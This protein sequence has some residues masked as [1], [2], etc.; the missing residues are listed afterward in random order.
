MT[1]IIEQTIKYS[2]KEEKD[3]K[4]SNDKNCLKIEKTKSS[5]DE[6]TNSIETKEVNSKCDLSLIKK[7][8]PAKI[9]EIEKMENSLFFEA[10]IKK[11]D[12]ITKNEKKD[13]KNKRQKNS[14]KIQKNNFFEKEEKKKLKKTKKNGNKRQSKLEEKESLLYKEIIYFSNFLLKLNWD[15]LDPQINQSSI[16]NKN[17]L[18]ASVF[19]YII[20]NGYFPKFVIYK[21]FS[22]ISENLIR[23]ISQKNEKSILI[24]FLGFLNNFKKNIIFEKSE[25]FDLEQKEIEEK[26]Q[27]LLKKKTKFKRS[28]IIIKDKIL[29]LKLR[30]KLSKH[31]NESQNILKKKKISSLLN[32]LITEKKKK[33][34]RITEIF[35]KIQ[36][37]RNS[38]K[39]EEEFFS[40]D[41]N[42]N[43]T[44]AKTQSVFHSKIP[45]T[46]ILYNLKTFFVLEEKFLQTLENKSKKIK[47][48]NI[49][50][51]SQNSKTKKGKLTHN[52][53][54]C[55]ICNNPDYN[56]KNQI[57]FCSTCNVSVHQNC[58]QLEKIPKN[59]WICDLCVF[60][61][62]QGKMVK[63]VFCPCLGGVLRKTQLRVDD[64]F[65]RKKN[66][67]FF[68][69][70]NFEG[71]LSHGNE[72]K[73]KFYQE[74]PPA[75]EIKL[76]YNTYSQIYNF[77]KEELDTLKTSRNIWAHLSCIFWN[78]KLEFK[79]G[80]LKNYQKINEK[81]F[82]AK[83]DI[84]QKKKQGLVVKCKIEGCKFRFHVECARRA[85]LTMGNSSTFYRGNCIFCPEHTPLPLK[86]QILTENKRTKEDI[87]KYLKILKRF[88]NNNEIET[89]TFEDK[90][91][92]E[93]KKEEIKIEKIVDFFDLQKKRLFREV[94]E[95]LKQKVDWK[96]TIKLSKTEN[97]YKIEKINLPKKF[98]FSHKIKQNAIL[99]KKIANKWDTTPFSLFRQ[100]QTL[101]AEVLFLFQNQKKF[102]TKKEIEST[103]MTEDFIPNTEGFGTETHC[104]CKKEWKGEVMVSCDRCDKWYHPK[105]LGFAQ[106]EEIR[107]DFVF[108]FQCRENIEQ[109]LGIGWEEFEKSEGKR[110]IPVF[111]FSLKFE[112]RR[113]LREN[114]RE[115]RRLLGHFGNGVVVQRKSGKKKVVVE[116]FGGIE[117][118][119]ERLVRDE[120]FE[121]VL[122]FYGE[123]GFEVKRFF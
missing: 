95:Q 99:W 6:K 38:L 87:K 7:K 8:I 2:E 16:F 109:E 55:Y 68:C 70:E 72:R 90:I 48:Q 43:L 11:E 49:I 78:S 28:K 76:F 27:N 81:D 3:I 63:C 59:D 93:T 18:N 30:N 50:K 82:F 1:S 35:Q 104:L 47:E 102:F 41:I 29:F 56:D 65:F 58:Y 69:Y 79:T 118:R 88:L 24:N 121:G 122:F 112:L 17:Y 67:G 45:Q 10:I 115:V 46:S 108:C 31:L 101:K 15:Q 105:C 116:D 20:S 53:M 84:C 123:K 96:F 74:M 36:K 80:I 13:T 51:Y 37:K 114:Q 12:F 73:K 21:D 40:R 85:K 4:D 26:I 98:I 77:E 83:C 52:D 75:E 103:G 39:Y 92:V 117:R 113:I 64:S 34:Q 106:N 89:G 110:E 5:S 23:K 14:Q 71:F 22:N 60:F 33:T 111:R 25:F 9:G 107:Q 91:D 119:L 32:S 86:K 66:E 97:T 19:W 57:V 44:S 61:G 94:K 100:F 62:P 120:G 42:E 54:I